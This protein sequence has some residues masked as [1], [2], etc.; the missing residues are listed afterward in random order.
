MVAIGADGSVRG[1]VPAPKHPG[2]VAGDD[3]SRGHIADHDRS[4]PD[5]GARPIRRCGRTVAPAPRKAPSPISTLPATTTPGPV[6]A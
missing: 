3:L 4:R 1:R 5:D 6:L 2:R